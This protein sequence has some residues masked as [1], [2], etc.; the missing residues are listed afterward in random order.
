M[1]AR[2][3]TEPREA[4][5]DRKVSFA[6]AEMLQALA[7]GDEH[8]RQFGSLFKECLNQCSF[9][10]SSLAGDEDGLALAAKHALEHAAKPRQLCFP[11]QDSNGRFRIPCR[12][13]EV[14]EDVAGHASPLR[15]FGGGIEPA[16]EAIA[17]PMRGFDVTR[18]LGIV[19]EGFAKLA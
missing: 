10:D 1:R 2:G 3:T 19:I 9:A 6:G 12:T 15:R 11:A 16:N 17:A 5:K 14:L 8:S 7:M 18:R 4:I 13:V